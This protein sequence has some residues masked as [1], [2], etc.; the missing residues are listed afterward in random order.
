MP[1]LSIIT[2]NLN[3]KNGLDQTIKSVLNQNCLNFE[4]IIIDGGSTDECL[5]LIK[6]YSNKITYWIS[7]P[8]NGIYNAMNKGI[9]AAKGDYC[10]F[11]NSGDILAEHNTLE[12]VIQDLDNKEI[13]Y[14]DLIINENIKSFPDIIP[15]DYFF[16]QYLPHPATFIKRELFQ[17]IGLYNENYKIA[18][19]VEFFIKAISIERSS[20]KHLNYPITKFDINGISSTQY[21]IS[22]GERRLINE[23]YFP[24]ILKLHNELVEVKK[25]LQFY[26]KFIFFRIL[27]KLYK[28][29]ALK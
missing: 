27:Q 18:S 11:I 23:K 20:Y 19:D 24:S 1:I 7:E 2:V 5:E 28:Q 10:L 16:N 8:D 13:V 6:H 17:K 25:Q 21:S 22:Q 29:I 14:G 9:L 12:K 3:N 4:Y 15:V 26:N